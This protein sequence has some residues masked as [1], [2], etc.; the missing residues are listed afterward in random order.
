MAKVN[1]RD[2]II[3]DLKTRYP[4]PS[5]SISDLVMMALTQLD[6]YIDLVHKGGSMP[7]SAVEQTS[8]E[9]GVS[10]DDS[11]LNSLADMVHLSDE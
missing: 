9:S 11:L 8:Q 2:R 10:L 3:K 4:D 7:P 5:L 6:L 1:L